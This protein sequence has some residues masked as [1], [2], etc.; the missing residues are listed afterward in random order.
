MFMCHF[1]EFFLT[2]TPFIREG[3]RSQLC[4]IRYLTM[5]SLP[6]SGFITDVTTDCEQGVVSTLSQQLVSIAI[7]VVQSSCAANNSSF[8]DTTD[9]GPNGEEMDNAF[10]F[11]HGEQYLRRG[12]LFVHRFTYHVQHT[13]TTPNLPNHPNHPNPQQPTIPRDNNPTTTRR[14]TQ[15]CPFF[16]VSFPTSFCRPPA[17]DRHLAAVPGLHEKSFSRVRYGRLMAAGSLHSQVTCLQSIPV[18]ACCIDRCGV[19]VHT[20]QVVSETTTTTGV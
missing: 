8:C 16:V 18:T 15:A 1:T 11:G 7:V 6:M 3:G 9:S 10:A 12:E 17:S 20:H 19:T 13:S 14:L 5:A 2:V 4:T